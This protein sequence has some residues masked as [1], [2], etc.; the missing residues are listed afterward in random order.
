LGR[1]YVT[2]IVDGTRGDIAAL[3]KVFDTAA[4][5]IVSISAPVAAEKKP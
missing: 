5:K 4:A 3:G 2:A 1:L